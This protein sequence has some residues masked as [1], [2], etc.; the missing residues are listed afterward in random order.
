MDPEKGRFWGLKA[1][2]ARNRFQERAFQS[3]LNSIL[4]WNPKWRSPGGP[5]GGA[6]EAKGKSTVEPEPNVEGVKAPVGAAHP[7]P[8]AVET[9]EA[10]AAA[11]HCIPR[12]ALQI[13]ALVSTRKPFHAGTCCQGSLG[14]AENF[15]NFSRKFQPEMR[16][17]ASKLTLHVHLWNYYITPHG[18]L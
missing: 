14:R 5:S 9:E 3:G 15:E 1:N 8:V 17:S 10:L 6:D 4:K 11:F 2:P 16:H 7:S 18:V 13:L 12:Q